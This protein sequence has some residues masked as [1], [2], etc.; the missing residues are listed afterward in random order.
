MTALW[1]LA[2]NMHLTLKVPITAAA[3]DIHKYFFIA[4]EKIRLDVS[5]ESSARQRIHM[6]KSSLIFFEN[7]KK[8][9]MSSDAIFVLPF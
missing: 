7:K 1:K 3:D 4:S 6:K 5:S 9:I 2:S 8:I